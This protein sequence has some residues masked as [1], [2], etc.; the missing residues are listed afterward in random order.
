[1]ESIEQE[2]QAGI[3]KKDLVVVNEVNR[4]TFV[5]RHRHLERQK[6]KFSLNERVGC[7]QLALPDRR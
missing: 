6:S 1:M 5:S 2:V 3:S 7:R 4:L